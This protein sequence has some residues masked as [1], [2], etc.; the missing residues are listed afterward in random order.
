[1]AKISQIPSPHSYII[2]D[3]K[4]ER[5]LE[6]EISIIKWSI[7]GQKLKISFFLFLLF[8]F[9]FYIVDLKKNNSQIYMI[10][11]KN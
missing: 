7:L 8:F 6:K 11:L 1:M 9:K 2:G 10:K 5:K 3:K 4:E